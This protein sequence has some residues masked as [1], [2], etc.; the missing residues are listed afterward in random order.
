MQT[1]IKATLVHYELLMDITSTSR[2]DLTPPLTNL[3]IFDIFEHLKNHGCETQ[4]RIFGNERFCGL[5]PVIDIHE[6]GERIDLLFCISDKNADNQET[7]NFES[8]EIETLAP[9]DRKGMNTRCHVVVKR[10]QNDSRRAQFVLEYK[11][12]MTATLFVDTIKY[13]VKDLKLSRPD[14]FIGNHPTERNN[15]GTPKEMRFKCNFKYETVFGAEIVQAFTRER[16]DSVIFNKPIVN[17]NGYDETHYTVSKE[18]VYLDV[19][20]KIV[21]RAST[22]YQ[23]KINDIKASFRSLVNAHNLPSDLTFTIKFRDDEG[24]TRTAHFDYAA[25]E[26]S[27]AKKTYASRRR[28]SSENLTIDTRFCDRMFAHIR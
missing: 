9:D 26:F 2:N 11:Q 16:V 4:N 21:Q 27:L 19:T 24:N 20:T 18:S 8:R 7:L 14:L 1:N 5:F 25:Q 15:D 28:I 12:G 23:Q 6:N 10:C 17:A 3:S 22:T 13:F